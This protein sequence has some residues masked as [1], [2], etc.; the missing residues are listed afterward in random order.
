MT[1]WRREAL[2]GVPSDTWLVVGSIL[3]YSAHC[4]CG[5]VST[6]R[7]DGP[8]AHNDLNEHWVEAHPAEPRH[9]DECSEDVWV[10]GC[11]ACIEAVEELVEEAAN[12]HQAALNS[13]RNEDAAEW[14]SVM[15]G[16]QEL[17]EEQLRRPLE[18]VA[19]DSSE[20]VRASDD[21]RT[22]KP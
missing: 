4:H 21:A 1:D 12:A 18:S 19:A 22:T 20:S 3:G 16:R 9:T 11:P 15:R 10:P 2:L 7:N 17:L 5:W 13:Y 14:L 6:M 8:Q